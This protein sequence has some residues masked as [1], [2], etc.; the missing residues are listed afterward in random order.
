MHVFPLLVAFVGGEIVDMISNSWRGG[1]AGIA[2]AA[3]VQPDLLGNHSDEMELAAAGAG[4]ERAIRAR[5][6]QGAAV[7]GYCRRGR[8]IQAQPAGW[9]I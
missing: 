3:G 6:S 8:A 7:A 9:R 5:V 2:C 1:Q 4:A